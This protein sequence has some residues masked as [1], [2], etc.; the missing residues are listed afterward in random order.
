M[1]TIELVHEYTDKTEK[2]Q[3]RTASA[4]PASNS[5]AYDSLYSLAMDRQRDLMRAAHQ[6]RL[7]KAASQDNPPVDVQRYVEK[8]VDITTLV[9]RYTRRIIELVSDS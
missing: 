4:L 8:R 9:E 1:I 2:P 3:Q 6:S 5:V 7:A